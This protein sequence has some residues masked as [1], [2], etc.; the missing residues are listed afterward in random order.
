MLGSIDKHQSGENGRT[1]AIG[2]ELKTPLPN[3][4]DFGISVCPM[5]LACAGTRIGSQR[6]AYQDQ[7]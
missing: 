5:A 2:R 1:K 7:N 3:F 4:S 6:E